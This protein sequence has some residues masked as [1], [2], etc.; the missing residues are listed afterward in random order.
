MR[1]VE[2]LNLMRTNP[3]CRIGTVT[4]IKL[5]PKYRCLSWTTV[6]DGFGRTYMAQRD[7]I[8]ALL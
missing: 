7:V 4:S 8:N 6:H 1:S 2:L 5:L 3:R